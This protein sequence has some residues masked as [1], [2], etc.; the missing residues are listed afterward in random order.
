MTGA[1]AVG[2]QPFTVQ[3]DQC[4]G[5]MTCKSTSR[6]A[7]GEPMPTRLLRRHY[8]CH[9]CEH[10]ADV[11]TPDEGEHHGSPRHD[12]QSTRT[13]S[14][15]RGRTASHPRSRTMRSARVERAAS[16]PWMM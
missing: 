11:V 15:W 6:V 9:R 7:S 10:E 12:T 4:G 1:A 16:S 5:P 3:C 2:A 14:P 13:I 8:Q